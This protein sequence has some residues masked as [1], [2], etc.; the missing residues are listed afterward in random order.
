MFIDWWMD[1]DSCIY[2]GILFSHKKKEILPFVATSIGSWGYYTKWNKSDR[3]RQIPY[4]IWYVKSKIRKNQKETHTEKRL[5]VTRGGQEWVGEMGD[6]GQKV[7]SSS[8]K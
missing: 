8:D 2:S 3:E 1:K 7:Q 4:D 6:H 5:V